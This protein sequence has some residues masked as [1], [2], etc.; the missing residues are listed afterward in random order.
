MTEHGKRNH[1]SATGLVP[2]PHCTIP[3]A[4]PE[5][6]T[7][8]TF[9]DD[10]SRLD[11]FVR[12]VLNTVQHLCGRRVIAPDPVRVLRP[13]ACTAVVIGAFAPAPAGW[14]VIRVDDLSA[15]QAVVNAWIV[16]E[17]N[18]LLEEMQAQRVDFCAVP[19]VRLL[20]LSLWAHSLE[21][22][23]ADLPLEES[24]EY[25]RQLATLITSAVIE[26]LAE[27]TAR[28]SAPHELSD[29]LR[30]RIPASCL[31]PEVLAELAERC[32]DR[33]P[34]GEP[35][36][37]T[38][39]PPLWRTEYSNAAAYALAGVANP[40][41]DRWA[42]MLAGLWL[43]R[44]RSGVA[45]DEQ[46]F[47][48]SPV[49]TA[50]VKFEELFI[51]AV[52]MFFPD[53]QPR[54]A[55]LP[56]LRDLFAGLMAHAGFRDAFRERLLRLQLTL[57]AHSNT[58]HTPTEIAENTRLAMAAS[59]V[60]PDE[61]GRAMAD[62]AKLLVASSQEPTAVVETFY[63]HAQE[64]LPSRG[65]A[66]F[67][68]RCG[69][70]LADI[71]QNRLA[72]AMVDALLDGDDLD[73]AADRPKER[74]YLM[75]QI[76]NVL[77]GAGRP[78][79]ALD[80]Y[81]LA[82]DAC[83]MLPEAES[84]LPAIRDNIARVLRELG[85]LS[86]AQA[87]LEAEVDTAPEDAGLR[88]SVALFCEQVGD[89]E[90]AL[91]HL[92]AALAVNGDVHPT[93][94]LGC[95]LT[96]S[97]VL[98]AMGH[99]DEALRSVLAADRAELASNPQEKLGLAAAALRIRPADAALVAFQEEC[100]DRLLGQPDQ[101]AAADPGIRQAV[102]TERVNEAL[103]EGNHA[104]ARSALETLFPTVTDP[105]RSVAEVSLLWA[106]VL[107]AEP[108]GDPWP[109][110]R[111]CIRALDARI[112]TG[113]DG[114]YAM[115]HVAFLRDLI[116]AALALAADIGGEPCD[117]MA[118][119]ELAN[120]RELDAHRGVATPD[121][122]VAD[123]RARGD[124]HDVVAILD[125][126]HQL[127]LVAVPA[128]R[129]RP[130]TVT[131]V[132][133]DAAEVAHAVDEVL[134]LNTANPVAPHW[135]DH[136]MKRWWALADRLAVAVR[137]LVTPGNG[138]VLL[139]GRR[140]AAAPLHAVGWPQQSLVEDGPVTICPNARVYCSATAPRERRSGTGLVAV[141]KTGDRPE[142][143][144]A[145]DKTVSY[146]AELVSRPTVLQNTDAD[147]D[148]VLAVAAVSDEVV[149]VCH[150]LASAGEGRGPAI[151]VAAEGHLPP[152]M[153]PVK[154]DEVLSAFALDWSSLMRIDAAPSLIVTVACSSGRSVTGPGGSRI[155]LEQG[156]LNRGGHAVI[157]PLWDVQQ[158]PALLWLR[159]FYAAHASGET[160][161]LA[162]AHRVATL[163]VAERYPHPFAWAP[164]VLT[165]RAASTGLGCPP[166]N[167]ETT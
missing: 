2:C 92:A 96:R 102:A 32:S 66:M 157:S 140:L 49:L 64:H 55:E 22:A 163:T 15:V 110:L 132:R 48:T 113:V 18:T 85:R 167:G 31:T 147:I 149:L 159:A 88:H 40:R 105:A 25:A 80:A 162:T 95:L 94:L 86:E 106:R 82:M 56:S 158:E 84:H 136:R 57:V 129:Q 155:G 63:H 143:V 1:R 50:T 33:L 6:V 137:E 71:G 97:N 34:F 60:D 119:Y 112:P 99:H 17:G 20:A 103:Q 14:T 3:M 41:S 21:T 114:P 90:G 68:A 76:G 107:A 30:V 39:I 120:G 115:G 109:W 27:D 78:Q 62:M 108:D 128:A 135:V 116:D 16:D 38:R 151:C 47:L 19:P 26:A 35:D 13:D 101:L 9:P 7:E 154:E 12:G 37:L 11:A 93:T 142:F 83:A 8:L 28:R 43:L 29:V 4:P 130:A 69:G 65:L 70:W 133:A 74:A 61:V 141:P 125:G 46:F 77:H 58:R 121:D 98:R 122:V 89:L 111:H 117:L 54:L 139:P 118:V 164:F 45:I 131:T 126:E 153:L 52:S 72:A 150:G 166:T 10:V 42:T 73:L 127:T 146:V 91:T 144:A 100:R 123:I 36:M 59:G 124:G 156:H 81:E 67:V 44:E 5:A 165:S 75:N 87:I 161:D 160:H 134:R 152:P 24:P 79:V 53:G 23:S 145:L 51:V 148:G 138:L 104:A